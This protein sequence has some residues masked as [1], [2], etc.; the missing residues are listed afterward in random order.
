ME[1][2]HASIGCVVTR[3]VDL[4]G[5]GGCSPA[6]RLVRRSIAAA[7]RYG[8]QIAKTF[9]RRDAEDGMV[10]RACGGRYTVFMSGGG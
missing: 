8:F 9:A 10:I 7:A 3:E 1:T 4:H 2:P 5:S 6:A